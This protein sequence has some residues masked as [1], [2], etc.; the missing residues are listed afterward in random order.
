ME[1]DNPLDINF[2]SKLKKAKYYSS[3]FPHWVIKNFFSYE[4]LGKIDKHFPTCQE[5]INAVPIRKKNKIIKTQN[6]SYPIDFDE[7]E[8][9]N[10]DLSVLGSIANCWISQKQEVLDFL[11]KFDFAINLDQLIFD[12]NNVESRGDFRAAT[13]AK[14]SGTT[15]LGPH[16][17]KNFE[18]LA[19][20]IYLKKKEDNT[21]GGD[22][23]LYKLKENA[24]QKYASNRLRVPVRYLDKLKTIEYGNNSAVF[25][26]SHPLAI[27]GVTP[28]AVGI[29]ERRLINFSLELDS[30]GSLKMYDTNKIIDYSLAP[31]KKKLSIYQ[32]ILKKIGFNVQLKTHKYGRYKWQKFE[33]L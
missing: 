6:S 12:G 9:L 4:E 1:K 15:Q 20:L 28:R 26:V 30:A 19:G 24:P 23:D 16:L 11:K 25:F 5:I 2:V 22:L 14:I 10:K 27:H 31:K 3:P 29:Y 33:D 18:I 32:R 13:P 17:D 7:L 21:V 8:N